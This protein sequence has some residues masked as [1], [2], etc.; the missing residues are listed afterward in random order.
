MK[1]AKS[2]ETAKLV[3]LALAP[4][5][6]ALIPTSM[7]EHGPTLCLYRLIL[8]VRCPGCGMTRAVSAMFQG[9]FAAA[10]GFNRLII[11][12]FP[13]LCWLYVKTVFSTVRNLL[14]AAGRGGDADAPARAKEV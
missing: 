4:V 11:I 3:L 7:I 2:L 10:F 1:R 8:G 12:V 13:L 14:S 5:L 6:L 9:D